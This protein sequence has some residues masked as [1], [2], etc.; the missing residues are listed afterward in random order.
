MSKQI[1]EEELNTLQKIVTTIQTL[2]SQIGKVETQKHILLV[3]S[4]FNLR[5]LI[6]FALVKINA[7][8]FC[9]STKLSSVAEIFKVGI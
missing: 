2:Q 7:S 1:K 3:F 4:F 5:F 6:E 9:A 8:Y